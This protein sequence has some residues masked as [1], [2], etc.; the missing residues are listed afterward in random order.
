MKQRLA[1]LDRVAGQLNT[2]LLVVAIG[3][4][5]L[6]MTVLVGKGMMAAIAQNMTTV[7]TDDDASHASPH[8]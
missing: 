4:G 1:H 3:L 7:Q 6:D 5:M 8:P 2:L